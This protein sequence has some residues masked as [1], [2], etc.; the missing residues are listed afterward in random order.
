[1]DLTEA[2][3]FIMDLSGFDLREADLSRPQ[4]PEAAGGSRWAVQFT[5]TT[6]RARRHV[7][8]QG[9]DLSGARLDC[10]LGSRGDFRGAM[11]VG[12]SLRS[13]DLREANFELADV[14]GADFSGSNLEHARFYGAV[15]DEST[16]WP[17]GFS[18]PSAGASGS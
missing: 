1:M 11:L 15:S 14:R 5:D 13:A 10:V 16:V 17:D 2:D 3:P 7:R 8:V 6:R 4:L 12:A 18:V 9:A